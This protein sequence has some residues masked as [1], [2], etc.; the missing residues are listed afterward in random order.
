MWYKDDTLLTKTGQHLA[1][2]GKDYASQGYYKCE[3][4]INGVII[5]SEKTVVVFE[6]LYI[7]FQV[8]LILHFQR[9]EKLLSLLSFA[10]ARANF[11]KQRIQVCEKTKRFT[12]LKNRFKISRFGAF[13]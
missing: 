13:N 11:V 5:S 6:G 7:L 4:R 2:D 10:R 1:I 8:V 12:F 9:N 3:T